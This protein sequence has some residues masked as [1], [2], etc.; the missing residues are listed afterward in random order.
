MTSPDARRAEREKVIEDLLVEIVARR[1]KAAD[2]S[3]KLQWVRYAN[4]ESVLTELIADQ[5]TP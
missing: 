2:M 3:L 1:D 4:A 5:E